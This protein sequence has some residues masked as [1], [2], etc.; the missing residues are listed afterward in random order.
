MQKLIISSIEDD[1]IMKLFWFRS[2]G[3]I[4]ID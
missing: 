2:Q 3:L 4:K 1:S